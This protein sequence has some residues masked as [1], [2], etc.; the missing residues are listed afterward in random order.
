MAK[1]KVEKEP[2]WKAIALALGQRVN[3]AITRIEAKGTGLLID[4]NT[5]KSRHWHDYML[6]GLEM[7]PGLKIDKDAFMALRL[8][9]AQRRKRFK[10]IESA[11][12]AAQAT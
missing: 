4:L 3:F 9:A 5:G 6:E 7:L 2:D 10:E 11:K 12:K 8:P 1:K